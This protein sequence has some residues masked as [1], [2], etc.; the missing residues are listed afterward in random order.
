MV[1]EE[2]A[3]NLACLLAGAGYESGWVAVRND[4]GEVVPDTFAVDYI[5]PFPNVPYGELGA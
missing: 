2:E 3:T 5:K 1:T 4:A